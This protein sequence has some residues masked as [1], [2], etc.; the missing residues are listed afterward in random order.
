MQCAV[1]QFGHNA[2][3]R[4]SNDNKLNLKEEDTFKQGAITHPKK[5]RK[6]NYS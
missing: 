2:S 5:R 4:I 3:L 1:A 6:G